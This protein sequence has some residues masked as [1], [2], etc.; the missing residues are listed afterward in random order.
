MGKM[1]NVLF[2]VMGVQLA[3]V[4]F[5]GAS[6]PGSSLWQLITNPFDWSNLDLIDLLT[7]TLVV[8]GGVI[9]IGGLVFG[10]D[11]AVFGGISAVLLS[12][13]ASLYEFW[14]YFDSRG[15]FFGG[16][17]ESGWIAI[18]FVS[19]IILLFIIVLLDF[20]RGKD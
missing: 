20:W 13:G 16:P 4:M 7:D 19:P 6:I 14:N 15:I 17:G 2:I 5:A 18:L 9:T 1:V 3:L 12:F 10:N 11:L 8:A